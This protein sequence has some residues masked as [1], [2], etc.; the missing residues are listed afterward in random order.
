MAVNRMGKQVACKIINFRRIPTESL[1]EWAFPDA[2][3][4]FGSFSEVMPDEDDI[5][6]LGMTRKVERL[7]REIEILKNIVH[8]GRWLIR[9]RM[10]A[11]PE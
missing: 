3:K 6:V 7:L 1:C 11:D 8:V 9:S 4:R 2:T 10:D 5:R